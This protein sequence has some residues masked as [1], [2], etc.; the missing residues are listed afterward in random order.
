MW[1]CERTINLVWYHFF[2]LFLTRKTS[3]TQSQIINGNVAKASLLY[4]QAVEKSKQIKCFNA[5]VIPQA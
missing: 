2:N 1:L 3:T 5:R 4:S